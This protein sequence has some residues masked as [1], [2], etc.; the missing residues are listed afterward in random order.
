MFL[1]LLIALI[2]LTVTTSISAQEGLKVGDTA[3]ALTVK[4]FI[5]GDKVA[6]L[7]KGKIYV[8]EFWA[9]WCPPCRGAI[10]HLSRL[11]RKY[12][13]IIVIGVSAYEHDQKVVKPFVEKMGD[14]MAYR[15]AL[16]AVP[17]GAEPRDGKMVLA[18]M[19]AAEQWFV[20][21]AFIVNGDGKIAWIGHPNGLDQPLEQI[22]AGKF[23]LKAA[24]AQYQRSKIEESLVSVLR[25]AKKSGDPAVLLE[26][27]DTAIGV[28]TKL[29]E[30]LGL[31]KFDTLAV[32]E[33]ELDSA[34][35]YGQR[36]I[37]NS[38]KTDADRLE[39]LA[40]SIVDSET[41]RANAKLASL[42]LKA[43]LR[44]DELAR[45]KVCPIADTLAKAYFVTGDASMAVMTQQR[46]IKLAKGTPLAKDNSLTERLELYQKSV[47]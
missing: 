43:A 26:I 35:E 28:D 47:K 36:L 16:D 21:R 38:F 41:K 46:A 40:S 15:V 12:K 18:W 14:Q 17:D 34:L 22:V 11:Q 2:L 39:R 30:L 45:G 1:R 6:Q 27:I 10:P 9:T 5:K 32:R 19:T 3:P 8:I 29:E 31:L 13:D 33:S 20:P 7:E 42:A 4:E 37:E 44:A 23:D 24:A 25:K